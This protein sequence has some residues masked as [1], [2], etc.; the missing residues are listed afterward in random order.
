MT[1][2]GSARIAAPA[3]RAAILVDGAL[4]I[5]DEH[6]SAWD[7]FYVDTDVEHAPL[8]FPAATT[9]LTVTLR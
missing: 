1:L 4:E 2:P 9:L 5:D 3:F 8:T 7:F 6:L